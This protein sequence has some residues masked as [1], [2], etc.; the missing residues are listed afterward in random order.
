[1]T[2]FVET[3]R[4]CETD[5]SSLKNMIKGMNGLRRVLI[6][7][8]SAMKELTETTKDEPIKGTCLMELVLFKT[9]WVFNDDRNLV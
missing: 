7:R 4:I 5:C 9:V 8:T 2:W 3:K 6:E 1:M